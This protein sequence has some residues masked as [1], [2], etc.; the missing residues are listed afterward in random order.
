MPGSAPEIS[1]QGKKASK[2]LCKWTVTMVTECFITTSKI[3]EFCQIYTYSVAR[4]LT[5]LQLTSQPMEEPIYFSELLTMSSLISLTWQQTWWSPSIVLTFSCGCTSYDSLTV[6]WRSGVQYV[7]WAYISSLSQ[8]S[9]T[10]AA[11]V[12]SNGIM[13]YHNVMIVKL[14][15][16]RYTKTA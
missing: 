16:H 12:D 3:S 2:K 7:N 1:F 15:S 5:L 8:A 14:R 9:T 6:W 13:G 11:A 4:R 10:A